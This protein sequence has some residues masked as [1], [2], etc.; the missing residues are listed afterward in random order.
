MTLGLKPVRP[1]GGRAVALNR[2]GKLQDFQRAGPIGQAADEAPLLER[3]DQAVNAGLGPQV[4]RVLHFIEGRRHASLAHPIVD[5]EQKIVLLARQHPGDSSKQ[6]LN[7]A[8]CSSCVPQVAP[9]P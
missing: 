5:E 7:K 3:G 6:N 8:I 2:L 4:Q 1:T 9:V